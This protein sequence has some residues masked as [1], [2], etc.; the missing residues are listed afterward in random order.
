MARPEVDH[1]VARLL[2]SDEPSIRWRVPTA[3]LGE[4][5]HSPPLRPVR[6]GIEPGAPGTGPGAASGRGGGGAAGPTP[7]RMT[8]GEARIPASVAP[9]PLAAAASA[10]PRPPPTPTRPGVCAA[11]GPPAGGP[12]VG[13]ES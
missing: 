5:P 3:V 9:T 12:A 4:D 7:D 2:A 11:A 10:P 13:A 8:G 1:Q 6:R